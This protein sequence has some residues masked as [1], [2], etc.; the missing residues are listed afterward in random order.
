LGTPRLLL[1]DEP[2]VGLDPVL[3]EQLWQTFAQLAADGM[4]LLVSSHV[5]DE[6]RRCDQLL[7]MRDG[8]VLAQESPRSLCARTGTGDVEHAF[9]ALIRDAARA[10]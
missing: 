8:D 1:L 3:R 9:L 2:T 4:S 7:L 10:A 6:A 5:M